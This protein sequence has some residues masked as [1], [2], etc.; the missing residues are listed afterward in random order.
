MKVN[1]LKFAP[2]LLIPFMSACAKM[3]TKV[4]NNCVSVMAS[5]TS[6]YTEF[7][8]SCEKCDGEIVYTFTLIKGQASLVID[9]TAKVKNGNIHFLLQDDNKKDY[10]AGT[11]ND[12]DE[13]EIPVAEFRT[14]KLTVK[15]TD[16]QGS[17]RLRWAHK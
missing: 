4:E 2:I 7:T 17:Y 3:P 11:I 10:Y 5:F 8:Y 1:I 12:Y 16:F 6:S 13:F 15:H 9:V 14:H